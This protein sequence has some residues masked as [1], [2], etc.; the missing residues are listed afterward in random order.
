MLDLL[1]AQHIPIDKEIIIVDDGSKIPLKSCITKYLDE[2]YFFHYRLRRNQGKGSALQIGFKKAT[3]NYVLIQ[4][5]DMEYLPSDIPTLLRP[6]M[7][8][9]V[10]AVY[11]SR[12][13]LR[14]KNMSGSHGI[15]NRFL[16]RVTNFL[17]GT[18]L[19]DMETG[20]KL[21]NRSLLNSFHLI[22]REFEIE[23]EITGKLLNKGIEIVEV[24]IHYA[25]REKGIAKIN[26]GDGFEAAFML[27]LLKTRTKSKFIWW[28]YRVFKY[29]GKR[30]IVKVKEL[31]VSIR[32]YGL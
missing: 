28:V 8:G 6:I 30:L 32:W 1:L 15:G 31:L 29:Y 26:I 3:G 2:P 25:Y 17:Y 24:P 11:G 10:M 20:Y 12:F 27:F 7:Q 14:P 22:G 19:S 16:T 4:D 18:K 21:L 13:M 23:P 5:A 9:K